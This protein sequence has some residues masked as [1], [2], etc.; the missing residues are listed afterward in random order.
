MFNYTI[1]TGKLINPEKRRLI[2]ESRLKFMWYTSVGEDSILT[3]ENKHLKFYYFSSNSRKE[4]LN[5]PLDFNQK[6]SK[7][8]YRT[9]LLK[10]LRRLP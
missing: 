5:V 2:K 7:I 10:L 9:D 1:L 6:R 4:K 3:N 8:K